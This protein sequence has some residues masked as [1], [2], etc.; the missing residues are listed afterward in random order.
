M[1][2]LWEVSL[3]EVGGKLVVSWGLVCGWFVVSL[4]LVEG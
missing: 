1:V 4:R 2:S 3:W